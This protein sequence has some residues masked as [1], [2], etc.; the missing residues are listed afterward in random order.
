[1][2]GDFSSVKGGNKKLRIYHFLKETVNLWFE[3]VSEMSHVV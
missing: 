2:K 3:C 1:M